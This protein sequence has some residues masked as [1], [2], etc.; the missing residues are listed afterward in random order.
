MSVKTFLQCSII[1]TLWAFI[2]GCQPSGT[3]KI[4]NERVETRTIAKPII[5]LSAICKN[6]EKDMANI[7]AQRTT[8]ALE[9]INQNLKICL[10]L[11]NHQQQYKLMQ[12][13][14]KMYQRFLTVDRN[15]EQQ[16]AFE[17]YALEMAQYPTIQ[18]SH[19]QALTARDQY[20]LKHKGQAYVEIID[21][22]DQQVDYRR[23]PDYLARIFAPY[24]PESERIF[25][26]T[27]AQQNKK[28]VLQDGR[29]LLSPNELMTRALFWQEYQN[30]YPNSYFASDAKFLMQKYRYYLFFGAQKSPASDSYSNRTSIHI[31]HLNAI[32]QLAQNH[33]S[34]LSQHA[35]QYLSFLDMNTEQRD[36]IPS[37]KTKSTLEQQLASYMTV[38]DPKHPQNKNCLSDAICI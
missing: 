33:R 10:P 13:S 36:A 21:L 30:L 17:H 18:Q 11:L 15:H 29:L 4:I 3:P 14:T 12:L 2:L 1:C 34:P 9:D 8:L 28:P 20:L 22:G 7:N 23:N 19:F 31:D 5:D 6:I 37:S 25:I 24:S 32:E 26:Q 35:A 27:L 16:I 38:Y